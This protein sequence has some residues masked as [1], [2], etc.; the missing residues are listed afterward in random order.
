MDAAVSS[1]LVYSYVHLLNCFFIMVAC[2]NV[3]SRLSDKIML[4]VLHEIRC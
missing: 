3:Q 2:K 4:D 1:S